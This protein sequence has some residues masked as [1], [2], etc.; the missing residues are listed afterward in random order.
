M[1]KKEFSVAV[2]AAQT[3]IRIN[4]DE[5]PDALETIRDACRN[6]GWQLRTWDRA[7]G[8]LPKVKPSLPAAA[9]SAAQAAPPGSP[10]AMMAA[11]GGKSAGPSLVEVLTE[12]LAEEPPVD[13]ETD[14]TVKVV[15]VVSNFHLAFA[16]GR[17]ATSAVLQHLIEQGKQ[18]EKYVVGLM[19]AEEKLPSEVEPLF[20]VIDHQ[21]PDEAEL[22]EILAGV[23][24]DEEVEDPAAFEY[25]DADAIVKAALGLTRLQAEG[26]FAASRV[27]YGDVR[28]RDVWDYKAKILNRDGLVELLETKQ[29]FADVG[30]LHGFKDFLTRLTTPDNLEHDDPEAGYKGVICVGPP[31]VG[32]SLLAKCLGKELSVPTL[33]FN[34]GNLMGEYVGVTERNTRKVIQLVR[35][36]APCVVIGD[37]INQ[38]MGSGKNSNS[39]VD[40]R[41]L[42]SFLTA[43]NDIVEPVFWFFTANDV[44]GMHPAFSRAER[45]DARVYVRLPDAAQRAEI[46]RIYV[47]KYFPA[48]VQ[49]EADDRHVELAPARA[50]KRFFQADDRRD[51]KMVALLMTLPP[52]DRGETLA[53]LGKKGFRDQIEA[54]LIDDD[55]WTPAEIKS[56]CR[57]ARRLRLPLDEAAKRVGHDCKGPD[58]AKMLARLDDWAERKGALDSETGKVFTREAVPDDEPDAREAAPRGKVRRKVKRLSD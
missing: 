6:Y 30:G 13:P 32:K 25:P 46:W 56:C 1:L 9:Q 10:L 48:Q 55:K 23:A 27:Q 14:D 58:G 57:L 29:G 11:L 43:L 33:L 19:P 20:H 24:S 5:I 35:R 50:L 17:E 28:A 51:D 36:M 37:E 8:L 22:R 15:L 3:G 42:G 44:E 31:G 39:A 2:G 12:F 41:M 4:T 52:E 7:A 54:R 40:N 38:T 47:A 34:P 49:G 18:T 21:L 53:A 45:I 26:V 16:G